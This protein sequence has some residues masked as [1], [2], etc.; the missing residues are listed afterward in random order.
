MCCWCFDEAE[1]GGEVL[2]WSESEMKAENKEIIRYKDLML[3]LQ[4]DAIIL[5]Q[6]SKPND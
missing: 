1:K 5:L 4:I 3:S 2:R 6:S